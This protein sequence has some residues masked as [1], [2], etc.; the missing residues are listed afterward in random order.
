MADTGL[1]Q[2]I[3]KKIFESGA[4]ACG[5]ARAEKL[6]REYDFLVQWIKSGKYAGKEYFE[7]TLALRADPEKIVHNAKTVIAVLYNYYSK[8]SLH[9]KQ[10]Y[11]ISKYAYGKDYHWVIQDKL[12]AVACFIKQITGSLNTQ[13]FVDTSPIFEKAWAQRAGL[14]WIGK[15]TLLV[16]EKTGTFHFIGLIVTDIEMQYDTPV[17]EKCGNCELCIN[18]CPTGALTG[19]HELDARKC[20]SNLTLDKNIVLPAELKD[21]FNNYIYGCDICQDACPWNKTLVPATEPHFQINEKL[22][23]LSREDLENLNE[24]NFFK[25]TE[26]SAIRRLGFSAFMRN[27]GFVKNSKENL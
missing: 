13:A 4:S 18:A 3:K 19:P 12:D 25:I 10:F 9:E 1:I 22:K 27:I 17:D 24:D 8:E 26:K 6:Q 2:E 16:N 14:G 7:R 5:C 23:G 11:R 15:N 20:I 21:K